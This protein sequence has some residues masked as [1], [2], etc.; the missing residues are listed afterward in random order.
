MN[1]NVNVS[2]QCRTFFF[3]FTETVTL[4]SSRKYS[5]RIFQEAWRKFYDSGTNKIYL[6]HIEWLEDVL[7]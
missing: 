4:I 3:F 5:D 1:H 6:M 7:S 2:L